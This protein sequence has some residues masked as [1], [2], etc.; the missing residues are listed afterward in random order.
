VI[1]AA[2]DD[3]LV[4]AELAPAPEGV[5]APLYEAGAR[6]SLAMPFCAACDQALELEQI[7]CDGCGAAGVDWQPVEPAGIVHAVTTVHRRQQGLIRADAPYHVLD[8]ELVSGH[9]VVMTTLQPAAA[10]PL[11]GDAVRIGFRSVGGIAVP[12][13]ILD[14]SEST[15]M[16]EPS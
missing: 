15:A 3:W 11:I 8:V 13:A 1:A 9:R 5:L 12:A 7:V 6:G 4:S 2:G 16:K 14:R 10:G